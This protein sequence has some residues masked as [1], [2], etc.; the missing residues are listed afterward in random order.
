MFARTLVVI[1]CATAIGVGLLGMR[2]QRLTTMHEMARLRDQMD[3]SRKGTWDMQVRIA[4]RM[5]PPKLAKAIER[6]KLRLEPTTPNAVRNTQL[7]AAAGGHA[8]DD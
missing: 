7:T 3:E 1:V 6:A 2:Q 4:A 8:T 5:D